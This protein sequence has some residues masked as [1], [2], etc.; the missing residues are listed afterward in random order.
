MLWPGK[1][2]RFEHTAKSRR[3]K[4][5][6]I[7]GVAERLTHGLVVQGRDGGVHER[8]VIEAADGVRGDMPVWITPKPH[9]VSYGRIVDRIQCAAL[10]L[11][12]QCLWIT[13]DA[14]MDAVQVWLPTLP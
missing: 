5:L 7:D 12:D 2:A 14:H 3:R 6:T 4:P 9:R 11:G 1:S 8:K 10:Q 13:R